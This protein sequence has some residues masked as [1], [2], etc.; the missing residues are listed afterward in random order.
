MPPSSIPSTAQGANEQNP[1]P[2]SRPKPKGRRNLSLMSLPKECIELKEELMEGLVSQGLAEQMDT[3]ESSRL[4]Y[5][6][7]GYVCIVTL[8]T[9]YKMVDE[10]AKDKTTIMTTPMPKELFPRSMAAPSMLAHIATEKYCDGLPLYRLEERLA[11]HGVELDR[12]TMC[13][14]L[15]DAGATLG[16]TIVEA[17]RKEAQ[18]T[19]FCIATDATGVLIQP[20]QSPKKERQPCKRGHFFVQIADKDHVFFEYVPRETSAA[21]AKMFHGFSGYV[22]ADAKS[23]HDVHFVEPDERKRRLNAGKRGNEPPDER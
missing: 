7:G 15:E 8:R 3:E 13:R 10:K 1:P 5:K 23:V 20:L 11:R 9:K 6:R 17:A 4:G 21:V 2:K 18:K 12:G 14:W 16:A 19:A 22:Q